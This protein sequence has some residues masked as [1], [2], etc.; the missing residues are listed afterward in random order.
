MKPRLPSPDAIRK[1]VDSIRPLTSPQGESPTARCN[2]KS[3]PALR[4]GNFGPAKVPKVHALVKSSAHCF[5]EAPTTLSIIPERAARR[6]T[7]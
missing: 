2:I 5:C 4:T 7:S 1:R 6:S 3:S